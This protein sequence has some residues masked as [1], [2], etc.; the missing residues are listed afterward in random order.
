[1]VDGTVTPNYRALRNAHFRLTLKAWFRGLDKALIAAAAALTFM[2]TAIVTMLVYGLAQALEL[3]ADPAVGLLTRVAVVAGWQLV[4]FVLLRSLREATYM[5]RARPYFDT[6]PIPLA[7]RLRA[8]LDV[9][10]ARL[11]VPLAARCLGHLRSARHRHR[12]D[13]DTL[14]ILL[15]L[16]LMSLCLN[17]TLL[18]GRQGASVTAGALAAFA[19]LG[20]SGLAWD[21]A[22]FGCALLAGIA[23]WSS[24]LPRPAPAARRPR[25]GAAGEQL[26]LASG[27]VLPLLGNEL[28]ANLSL[29][30]GCVAAT[31]SACLLVMALRTN[32]TSNA[33]VLLFV[34]AAATLAL[35]SLPALSRNT[36][37]TRLEF[38]AGQPQFARRMRLAVYGIPAALFA[39]ALA[40]ASA[41]DRSARPHVDALIFAVLFILGVIGARLGWHPTSWLM[42]VLTLITLVILGAMT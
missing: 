5:P 2:L 22:R 37:F 42:P 4:S 11:F 10:D 16:V 28:K 17:I 26:A 40:I 18:R 19:L 14:A 24:Y 23:L 25:R 41:F 9:V 38:L 7:D 27:L 8:D 32:D 34:A 36:L 15:E 39:S 21:A 29:R 35:Y 3:L 1:M 20:G 13:T 6:L 12:P 30:V 31:L 33:S